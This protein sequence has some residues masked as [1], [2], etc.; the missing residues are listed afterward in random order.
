MKVAQIVTQMERGGAQ[1]V[2]YLLHRAFADLGYDSQLC[3]LYRKRPSY[4]NE[5]GVCCLW[6]GP[7]SPTDYPQI[8]SRIDAWMRH[9][10]PDAVVTHTHY[11]NVLG[12]TV[13]HFLRIPIRIA[14]QHSPV[15]TFPSPGRYADWLCGSSGVYTTQVAV[16]DAVVNSMRAYPWSYRKIVRRIYNGI[17]IASSSEHGS[18]FHLPLHCPRPR[19]LHVGRFATEKNHD[20]LLD[21]L[22][23]I[24]EANL[25]LV[26]DGER[27]E[28]IK[29]R[30]QNS[31]LLDRVTF[32]GEI[33]P[34]HVLAVMRSC[35]VF[36]FPSKQEAMPLALLEAMAVGMT[37][38]A[39]DIPA[40]RELLN[41][42]GLVTPSDSL[43]FAA[44]VK[45]VLRDSRL[46]SEMGKQAAQRARTFTV[47]TM[48]QGYEQILRDR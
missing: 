5:P 20:L 36:V 15:D 45:R 17:D 37:I 13:A 6:D 28:E 24:P 42:T 22:S 43:V 7:P 9:S 40:N 47:A 34:E 41:G 21:M 3:F 10:R 32:L 2:A 27:K 26:G 11:A 48:V 29:R 19:L 38:V 31:S 23:R 44:A 16:S 35:D 46:A 30:A 14:V 8:T 18:E 25:I 4:E 33:C 39:T 12:L 1:R